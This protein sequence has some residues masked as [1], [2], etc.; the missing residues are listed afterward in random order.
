[1]VLA[2]QLL[3]LMNAPLINAVLWFVILNLVGFDYGENYYQ[4]IP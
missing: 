4:A 1:L 3:T 2:M